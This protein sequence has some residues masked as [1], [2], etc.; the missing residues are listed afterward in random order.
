MS[1]SDKTESKKE[2][3][4]PMRLAPS[5]VKTKLAILDEKNLETIISYALRPKLGKQRVIPKGYHTELYFLFKDDMEI[6]PETFSLRDFYQVFS[7]QIRFREPKLSFRELSGRLVSQKASWQVVEGYLKAMVG[8]RLAE[9]PTLIIDESRYF[10]ASYYRYCY[11]KI[12][13]P[14]GKFASIKDKEILARKLLS[15]LEK[16]EGVFE[17]LSSWRKLSLLFDK[18]PPD[19]LKDLRREYAAISEYA[20]YVFRECLFACYKMVLTLPEG[21]V[22]PQRVGRL[23]GMLRYERRYAEKM[24]L[25]WLEE[26]Q[27]EEDWEHFMYRKSCL[28]HR[29]MQNLSLKLEGRRVLAFQRHIGPMLAAAFAGAWAGIVSLMVGVQIFQGEGV[30]SWDGVLFL[31]VLTAAYVL[32]DRIK[33]LGRQAFSGG[34]LAKL[35]DTSNRMM[36]RIPGGQSPSKEIGKVVESCRYLHFG[37]LPADVVSFVA[38]HG[39]G[40]SLRQRVLNYSRKYVFHRGAAL[41]VRNHIKR[42][43]EASYLKLAPFVAH[44][45]GKMVAA[46]GIK[47]GD[48]ARPVERRVHV[49][50]KFD[51]VLRVSPKVSSGDFRAYLGL[52]RLT[53]GH[54]GLMKIENLGEARGGD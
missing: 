36:F 22:A 14:L 12:L 11:R 30:T 21:A 9:P 16:L 38:K 34:V 47:D 24:G 25:L 48:L 31:G 3:A 43:Y 2:A 40:A 13:R 50:S 26:S 32:K 41:E 8:G 46:T 1:D 20:A 7:S 10:G 44:L 27:S 39:D 53:V 42:V 29:A 37:D 45:Q 51:L 33:E 19:F 18:L 4:A 23:K 17:V 5:F 54:K 52:F 35:P 49:V 15:V 6:G 28:H